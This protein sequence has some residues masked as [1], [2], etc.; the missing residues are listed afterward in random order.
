MTSMLFNN[1][2]RKEYEMARMSIREGI[3]KSR[4]RFKYRI[5]DVEGYEKIRKYNFRI[6]N[7]F[8]KDQLRALRGIYENFANS[9][10]SH[11]SGTLRKFCQV[12][13]ISVEEHTFS[14]FNNAINDPVLL[15]LIGLEPLQGMS[16]MEI[17]PS[18]T[19]GFID[20]LMGGTGKFTSPN[21]NYTEI[22]I[23][24]MERLVTQLLGIM[25]ESW[26]VFYDIKPVLERIETRSQFAQIA[27]PNDIIAIITF[28]VKMVDVEGTINY[29]IPHSLVETLFKD[30]KSKD[31]PSEKPIPDLE[32]K[33]D[34]I[35]RKIEKSDVFLRAAFNDTEILTKNIMELAV[36]DILVLDHKVNEEINISVMD[37]LKYKGYM[38]TVN[39]R[40]ALKISRKTDKE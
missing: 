37:K 17:S 12:E 34:E 6:P 31:V 22:E 38:G 35:L 32:D 27:S 8:T 7:R 4:M 40:K 26:S 21:R 14:E 3:K 29:C 36:G 30:V 10:S 24:L 1:R 19:C 13:F 18:I 15:A 11:L 39:N 2:E 20:R 23:A 25:K 5:G 28:F 16:L 33:S 9:A